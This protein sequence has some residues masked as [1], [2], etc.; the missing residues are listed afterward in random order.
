MVFAMLSSVDDGRRHDFSY[1]CLYWS[2]DLVVSCAT[3]RM[4]YS[5]HY[6]Y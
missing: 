1:L 2:E 4:G 3:L 5:S 6:L